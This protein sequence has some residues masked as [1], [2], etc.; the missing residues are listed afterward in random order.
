M[1]W[2]WTH[3]WASL[4]SQ[5]VHQNALAG[6]RSL[7]VVLRPRTFTDHPQAQ[8]RCHQVC[9]TTVADDTQESRP[10]HVHHAAAPCTLPT[11]LNHHCKPPNGA[12]SR[13]VL[14]ARIG[15]EECGSPVARHQWNEGED[16][17]GL[18]LFH[19]RVTRV[20]GHAVLYPLI[21][22]PG[23]GRAGPTGAACTFSSDQA[24]THSFA[25]QR[26]P[27]ETV[28]GPGW[29]THQFG[30]CCYSRVSV[31]DVMCLLSRHPASR[32]CKTW[33]HSRMAYSKNDTIVH[34]V[35]IYALYPFTARITGRRACRPKA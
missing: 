18:Q 24:G 17:R 33:Q 14:G 20:R 19:H 25:E 16:S 4:S 21:G 10:I 26:K 12:L 31:H 5:P 34:V 11:R 2:T 6:V 8:A 9:N 23:Y 22:W 35:Q 32:S 15:R 28:V 7:A 27:V 1:Q 13:T 3:L 29:S 30:L